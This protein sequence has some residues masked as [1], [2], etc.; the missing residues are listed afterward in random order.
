MFCYTER[1]RERGSGPQR[2]ICKRRPCVVS[3]IECSMLDNRE[4]LKS[5]LDSKGRVD[6]RVAMDDPSLLV[7]VLGL[8]T[9]RMADVE[10]RGS[11]SS[12]R[13][14]T[15]MKGGPG[16]LFYEAVSQN[17]PS[18]SSRISARTISTDY[19]SRRRRRVHS[20]VDKLVWNVLMIPPQVPIVHHGMC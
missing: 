15:R 13:S 18:P 16:R 4:R 6:M 2:H 7:Y 14:S 11:R 17:I 12:K 10:P 20:W 19:D 1:L 8:V 5:R 3:M 9:V